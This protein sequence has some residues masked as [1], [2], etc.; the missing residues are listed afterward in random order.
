MGALVGQRHLETVVHRFGVFVQA[1]QGCRTVTEV[2]ARSIVMVAG[3]VALLLIA[4]G[5][6]AFVMMSDRYTCPDLGSQ[7][8]HLSGGGWGNAAECVTRNGSQFNAVRRP[9]EI[10]SPLWSFVLVVGVAAIPC[11]WLLVRRLGDRQQNSRS[12]VS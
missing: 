12:P 1:A 5:I 8:A 4:I 2:K 3:W 9:L 10:T 11:M 7:E 6:H